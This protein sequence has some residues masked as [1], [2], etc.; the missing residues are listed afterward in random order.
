MIAAPTQYNADA[1]CASNTICPTR[2]HG[3]VRLR[4]TVTISGEVS[5][6]AYA[7]QKSDMRDDALLISTMLRMRDVGGSSKGSIPVK[8]R[9]IKPG[10]SSRTLAKPTRPKKRGMLTLV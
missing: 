6:M 1:Y 7:Q 8:C 9:M 2:L 10:H 4:P 3:I 5:S